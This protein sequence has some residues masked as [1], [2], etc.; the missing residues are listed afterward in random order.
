MNG[1]EFY[2]SVM[3]KALYR[4]LVENATKPQN[5]MKKK[6]T[7]YLDTTNLIMTFTFIL[8]NITEL[9]STTKILHPHGAA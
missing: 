1:F 4:T 3:S 9:K 8:R 2:L 6:I 5:L 7:L